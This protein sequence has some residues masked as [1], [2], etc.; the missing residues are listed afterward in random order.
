[1]SKSGVSTT[2]VKEQSNISANSL[3]FLVKNTYFMLSDPNTLQQVFKTQLCHRS[4]KAA[5]DNKDD[6]AVCQ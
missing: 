6:T 2:F 5:I 1:M 4:K 3:C